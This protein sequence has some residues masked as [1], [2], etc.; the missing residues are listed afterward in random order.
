MDYAQG[1]SGVIGFFSLSVPGG[2]I[3]GQSKPIILQDEATVL[4]GVERSLAKVENEVRDEKSGEVKKPVTPCYGTA[5]DSER[6]VS[7]GTKPELDLAL[8]PKRLALWPPV[9]PELRALRDD[10]LAIARGS[11]AVRSSFDFWGQAAAQSA[12]APQAT[13]EPAL[14]ASEL[15]NQINNPAAPVT[16]VQFRNVLIPNIPGTGG[17]TY[18]LQIQPVIPIHKSKSLPFLQLIKM[19]LPIV[20][21]PS[22]VSKTGLGDL[23]FFDLVSIKQSWGRWGFGPALVF[24]TATSK[25][26]GAGKWQA[27]P[28]F[29]VIYTRIE[30]LTVGASFRT[31]S[32]S[33]AI[34]AGLR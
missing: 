34:R 3:A 23:Q 2:P 16:L 1:F 27:G 24:P 32:L 14:S 33:R 7:R 28:S 4:V 9:D 8:T 11:V 18:A 17:V 20:S 12:P 13:P 5:S 10:L 31:R 25:A 21:A 15:A 26:L 30:N 22:P 6:A 29:A 19:T